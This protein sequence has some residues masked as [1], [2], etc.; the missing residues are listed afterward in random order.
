MKH[1]TTNYLLSRDSQN[2]GHELGNVTM[3]PDLIW[4]SHT[5]LFCFSLFLGSVNAFYV[6]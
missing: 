6:C 5:F 3:V 2:H 1:E 4:N